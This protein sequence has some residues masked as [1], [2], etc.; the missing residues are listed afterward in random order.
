MNRVRTLPWQADILAR[1]LAGEP[2]WSG[3]LGD[4][5]PYA[6][7]L[8]RY[9]ETH[10]K[11]RAVK[12]A[13]LPPGPHTASAAGRGRLNPSGFDLDMRPGAAETERTDA[14]AID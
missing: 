10:E 1:E 13:G 4:Y 14:G 2:I 12:A 8:R 11:A 9:R 3:S 5:P 7:A 6:E